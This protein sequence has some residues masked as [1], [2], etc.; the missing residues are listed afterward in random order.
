MAKASKAAVAA[1]KSQS[2]SSLI[3]GGPALTEFTPGRWAVIMSV[4]D[5]GDSRDEVIDIKQM[6]PGTVPSLYN[7][8]DEDN[9]NAS[10]YSVEQ[11]PADVIIGMRRGGSF[12]TV[13]GF[14]WRDAEDKAVRG[15]PIGSGAV[16]L[17]DVGAK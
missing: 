17:A 6:A 4:D 7:L 1:P 11:V 3:K 8:E 9:D 5:K 12:E 15:N 16:R 14:G 13:N 2:K 10:K